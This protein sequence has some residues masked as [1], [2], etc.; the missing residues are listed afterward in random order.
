MEQAKARQPVALIVGVTGMVGVAITEALKQPTALG[1]PWTVYGVSRRSLPTWFPSSLLDKHIMLDT[2]NQQQTH[3]IMAPLSSQ[4]THVF[5]VAIQF[6]ESEQVSISLNSTMLSNVL[7]ALTSFPNS[8]LIHVSLQTGIKQYVGP[9]LDPTL[10]TQIIPHESPFIEDYPRLP[11]PNFYHD[12]EDILASYSKSITYSI[13]RPSIIIGAS[14]RSYFNIPLTLAVYALV[15]KHQ[16]YPFRYVGNKYS[17]EHFWDVSDARV[18]AEQHI[19]ASVTDKAKNKAFNCTNG[20]V[21]TWK[22]IW[23]VL[24]DVFGV[25]FVPFDEE[26]KFDVVEFMKDKGEVWDKIVEE[27]GLYKTKMEEITC[28]GALTS[29]LKFEFQHVCSMNKSREFGFHGYANTLKSIPEWVHRLRQMK[30]L[31]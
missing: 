12:L 2:L 6:R 8:K 17:W 29:L 5:W 22:M 28:F 20:D 26:E 14:T 11:F 9:F 23:K 1:G 27:N 15:C 16:N 25:E 24:C 7:N 31:P 3:E 21:F 4:I 10:S 30:I 18:I 13:H 19:W